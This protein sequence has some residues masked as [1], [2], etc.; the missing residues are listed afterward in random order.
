MSVVN[1]VDHTVDTSNTTSTGTNIMVP[2]SNNIATGSTTVGNTSGNTAAVTPVTPL[3]YTL[4]AVTQDDLQN[5]DR[6][7]LFHSNHGEIKIAP[8]ALEDAIIRVFKAAGCE[9]EGHK[10]AE[11]LPPPVAINEAIRRAASSSGGTLTRAGMEWSEVKTDANGNRVIMIVDITLDADTYSV[12]ARKRAAVLIDAFGKPY[13][14]PGGDK[15]VAGEVANF[16]A[17]YEKAL[18]S[19]TGPKV[20]ATIDRCKTYEDSLEIKGHGLFFAKGE[21]AKRIILLDE[22]LGL[23][24]SQ[25]RVHAIP[26]TPKPG[27]RHYADAESS[28]LEEM[29]RLRAKYEA[30]VKIAIDT[31]DGLD[32]GVVKTTIVKLDNARKQIKLMAAVF[33]QESAEL[34]DLSTK[35][36]ND[37]STVF[38]RVKM[39]VKD[40]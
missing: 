1:I 14:V 20:W 23:C 15:I 18:G 37:A 7:F 36:F 33:A 19:V 38:S 40:G 32:P 35:I 3:P 2:E 8:S 13:E 24:K 22:A 16:I 21:S 12:D 39:K 28:L 31:G 25:Y 9:D 27:D 34:S 26:W 5:L 6:G 30:A 11:M 4:T 29:G 17:S 10:V